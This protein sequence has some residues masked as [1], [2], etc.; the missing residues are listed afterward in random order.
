MRIGK[1]LNLDVPGILEVALD[2]DGGVGEIRLALA[3]GRFVGTLGV[4]GTRYDT[5]PLAAAAGRGL[6]RDR[7]ADLV[8][9]TE[10]VLDRLDRRGR[11]R[12]DRDACGLHRLPGSGLRA[13]HLDRLR[14]RADPDESGCLARAREARVL[15]EEAV[16]GVN[17]FRPGARRRVE[18]PHL[19]EVAI[20]RGAGSDQKGL[21]CRGDVQRASVGL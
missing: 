7:P 5:Q 12:H 15:G 3:A 19:V 9:E 11:A 17:R 6:D 21:V 4:V 10:H 16:T 18:Q 13:H 20:G 1:D 2:V 14:R 8:A